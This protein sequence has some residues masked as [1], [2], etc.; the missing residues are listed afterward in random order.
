MHDMWTLQEISKC[1]TFSQGYRML[2]TYIVT[3]KQSIMY[4]IFQLERLI[5]IPGFETNK[6]QA[7]I[8]F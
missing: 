1:L 8:K 5:M 2:E 3:L 7:V 6:T 4:I